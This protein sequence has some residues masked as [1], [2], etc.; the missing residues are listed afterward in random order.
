ML[1]N[2]I[3]STFSPEITASERKAGVQLC[4]AIPL[5]SEER[6]LTLNF[7]IVLLRPG[8]SLETNPQI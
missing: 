1:I 8:I 3:T 2:V 4:C 7:S 5:Q 6:N